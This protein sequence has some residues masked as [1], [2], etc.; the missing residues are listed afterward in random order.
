MV[1]VRTGYSGRAVEA[2]FIEYKIPHVLIGGVSLFGARHVKD[3]LSLLRILANRSDEMAWMRYL[4]LWPGIG[5]KTAD[6]IFE[7]V[8]LDGEG[9]FA[10]N[11]TSE[12]LIDVVRRLSLNDRSGWTTPLLRCLEGPAAPADAWRRA[13]SALDDRLAAIYRNDNWDSRQKD[14]TYVAD[15]ATKHDTIAGFIDEYL[16]NPVYESEIAKTKNE[17]CVTIITIHSAKG[18]EASR[19][20]VVD[21]QP[22]SFPKSN[23]SR[24]K[25]IEEERRV[26]YVAMT[27]AADELHVCRSRRGW[28]STR[29]DTESESY[30]LNQLPPQLVEFESDLS[31]VFSG[32]DF[33]IR[34]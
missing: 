29:R 25:E 6:H 26:L 2:K 22:G 14:F 32:S 3:V 23:G 9:L 19:C 1:L 10:D 17:D 20:F 21:V 33:A 30:F 12:P 31:P 13:V 24:L 15:L 18:L 28:V 7:T 34:F 27:R 16:L 4:Q 5:E 8:A 11:V